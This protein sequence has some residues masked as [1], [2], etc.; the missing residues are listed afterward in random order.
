[1]GINVCERVRESKIHA[2][3]FVLSS[4]FRISSSSFF[5]LVSFISFAYIFQVFFS[6]MVNFYSCSLNQVVVEI[7]E[8]G[9][10]GEFF[11]FC[12]LDNELQKS[13]ASLE[14]KR[15]RQRGSWKWSWSDAKRN[16]VLKLNRL[17]LLFIET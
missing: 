3:A 6:N 5:L 4:N 1:M 15:E 17:R 12:K 7:S 2:R 11:F 16:I 14:K 10:R 13:K 9:V 8:G